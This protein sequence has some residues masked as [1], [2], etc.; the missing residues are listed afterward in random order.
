MIYS[1]ILSGFYPHYN[2]NKKKFSNLD[3]YL[4]KMTTY[5]LTNILAALVVCRHKIQYYNIGTIFQ[6]LLFQITPSILNTC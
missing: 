2:I 6:I 5:I 4:K 1:K 3:K